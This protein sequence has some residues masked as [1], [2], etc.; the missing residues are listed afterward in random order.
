M[1]KLVDAV[2]PKPAFVK[3]AEFELSHDLSEW[4]D[5]ILKNFYEQVS[6]LPKE[7]GV[8]IIIKNVDENKGYAKGSVVVFFNGK[9]IN[10]PIIV[11]DYK[12]SPFDVFVHKKG[13]DDV[14]FPASEDAV[15]KILM[16]DQIAT[17]ENRWDQSRGFQVIKTPGGVQP[18][19][20]ISLYDAPEESLYPPF[21]KMSG[22]RGLAKKEDLE[23]FAESLIIN[24]DIASSFHD[25]TGDLATGIAQLK[26]YQREEVYPKDHTR[27]VLDLNNIIKA[28]RAITALDSD[29]IDTSKL[30]PL[31]PPCVSEVRLYEYPSMEDFIETG[32]N[33]AERFEATKIG[34]PVVGI[35][36]DLVDRDRFNNGPETCC[37]PSSSSDQSEEQKIKALRKRR[38]QIFFSIYGKF[39][40]TFE[41]WDKSG[42]GFYGTQM[43]NMPEAIERAMKMFSI[44][45]T[46]DFINVN[47][48]NRDDGSDKLFAGFNIME[49]GKDRNEGGKYLENGPFGCSYDKGLFII[50]GAANAYECVQLNGNFRKYIVNNSHVYVSKDTVIIPANIASVQKVSSVKDP[51]YKMIVGKASNIYLMPESSLIVNRAFMKSLNRNDFMRPE[52]PVQ[53]MYETQNIT[54]VALCVVSD[55][56]TVGYRIDGKPFDPMKK[57]A[58]I[59]NRPLSTMETKASLRILGMDKTASDRAMSIAI[60][61]FSNHDI[62]DKSVFIYGV[63]GDYI[64]PHIFDSMEKVARV[65]DM[66]KKLAYD[67]RRDLTKEA[68]ALTDPNAADVVL[69]LN[70]I[71]EESLGN[72][73]DNIPEMK[74]VLSELAQLLVAS[75]MGMSDIDETATKNAMT[76]LE[77]VISGL[78]NIKMAVR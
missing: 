60:Q 34:K 73:V 15:K 13:S 9:Q 26:K 4:N 57:I 11:K 20:P 76:G 58:H 65:K 51:V 75:R 14:Y 39:Y 24:P 29:L 33:A 25:N 16:S 2:I 38:D 48:N 10:F 18:K 1:I 43:L 54:K 27:G 61:K 32:D 40:C 6:Y 8:N 50:Y 67:I 35:L 30:I 44:A 56:K 77:E 22:W 3:L 42:I 55:G 53:K 37:S 52:L 46:D 49:Q 21:A 41:D 7:I 12:L 63:N 5:A 17:L 28:K 78:E 72:Y 45:T 71:N 47:P 36:L 23:K 74:K 59:G 66:L 69:S 64:N 19:Q 68:S 31:Q 62:K 70:F